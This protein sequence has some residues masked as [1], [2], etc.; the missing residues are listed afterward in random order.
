M[1]ESD[2][3]QIEDRMRQT[4]ENYRVSREALL[5]IIND[6][7]A[8]P[9]A[10]DKVEAAKALVMLDLALLKAEIETG[11]YKKP[12]EVLAREI[13]YEPSPAEVRAVAIEAW[14]R[15]GMLPKGTIEEIVPAASSEITNGTIRV[16]EFEAKQAG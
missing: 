9:D 5:K 3:A 6:E 7:E 2:R 15:R 10:R 14:A 12:V 4:R 13:H 8:Y 1:V 11:M 16:V